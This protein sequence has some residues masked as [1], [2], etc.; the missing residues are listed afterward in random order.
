MAAQTRNEGNEHVPTDIASMGNNKLRQALK[1]AYGRLGKIKEAAEEG[2]MRTTI[3]AGNL[4]GAAVTGFVLG[5]AERDGKKLTIGT[6][7]LKWTTVVNGGLAVAGAFAPRLVGH[8]T[9]NLVLGLGGGGLAVEVGMWGR[10]QGLAA[11]K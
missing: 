5:R 7:K 10:E 2:A 4:G 3:V 11:K 8:T 6:S 9:A 1:N